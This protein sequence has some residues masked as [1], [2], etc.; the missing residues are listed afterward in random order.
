[1][2]A[3][4]VYVTSADGTVN[5]IDRESGE[6]RWRDRHD[7]ETGPPVPANGN[8]YVVTDNRVLRYEPGPDDGSNEGGETDN[9]ARGNAGRLGFGRQRDGE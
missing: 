9:G 2:T 1:V 6:M 8:L 7:G 4:T 3:D 5:A